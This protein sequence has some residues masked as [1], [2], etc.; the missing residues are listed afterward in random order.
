MNKIKFRSS[1]VVA[2]L[3]DK[4]LMNMATED[5]NTL[6]ENL[7]WNGKLAKNDTYKALVREMKKLWNEKF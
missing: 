2:Y 7:H 5:E 1:E 3:E 4:I 6:Y